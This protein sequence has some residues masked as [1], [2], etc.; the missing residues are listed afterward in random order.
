MTFE[1]PQGVHNLSQ[2]SNSIGK[3]IA[4]KYLKKKIRLRRT[5]QAVAAPCP[6]E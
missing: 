1:T 6:S 4:T 5:P 2:T 3:V